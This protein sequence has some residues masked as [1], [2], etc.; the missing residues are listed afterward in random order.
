M[1]SPSVAYS[2]T[3]DMIRHDLGEKV[4]SDAF[5]AL[6]FSITGHYPGDPQTAPIAASHLLRTSISEVI[7]NG[8]QTHHIPSFTARD[9]QGASEL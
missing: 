7:A 2:T 6:H 3:L 8:H 4:W 5:D 1:S 9:Q